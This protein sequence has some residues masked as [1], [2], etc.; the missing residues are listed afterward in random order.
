[1]NKW[2]RRA[3]AVLSIVV[4]TACED[5]PTSTVRVDRV[6]VGPADQVLVVGDSTTITAVPMTADGDVVVEQVVWRN[7]RPDI[8][9]VMIDG[10]TAVVA[11]KAPGVARIEAEAGGRTGFV[12][13]TVQ[14]APQVATVTVLPVTLVLEAGQDAAVEAVARTADGE[15]ITGRAVTWTV[16]GQGVLVTPAAVSGWATV[17][18]QLYGNATVRA[19]IDGIAGEA[20]VEVVTAAP[21]PGQVATVEITPSNFSLPVNHETPL[22][23]IAKDANGA[24]ISGRPVIWTS[25]AESVASITPIG[26]SQ[27]ASLLAKVS[28]E[29]VIRATV[30]G[31]TAE[32]TVQVTTLPPPPQEVLYLSFYPYQ[33]GIWVNQV[34]DFNQHLVATGR[35]GRIED[36]EVTWTVEDTTIAIVDANGNVRGRSKGT[37]QIRASIGASLHATALVTV[38]ATAQGPQVFDLTYD[39]WDGQWHM[40][41]TVGTEQW[42]DPN[43]TVRDVQLWPTEGTLTL[44]DDGAYER[45][46]VFHGWAVVNGVNQRVIEHAVV[47]TGTYTIMVGGATGYSMHSSTTPG[48]TY[49]LLPAYNAGHATMRAA[50]GT[51][52][53]QDYLFR[54]RQ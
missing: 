52:A 21:P 36:P 24:I 4:L 42:T 1:M 7:L 11:A 20:E 45:V 32:I 29:A 40:P 47:D 46:M 30:D 8:A 26:V 27:F 39:W 3:A 17:S 37:T 15:I 38:F 51:A 23:A 53:E 5:D 18:A 35:N 10:G 14:A 34:L 48:Y 22:Q 41:P 19:T 54:M 28:G 16:E 2:M 6:E 9:T 49:T 50:V 44:A 31:I 13:V 12:N 43:G 25:T 33:R